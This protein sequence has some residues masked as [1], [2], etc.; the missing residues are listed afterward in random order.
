M[1][2]QQQIDGGFYSDTPYFFSPYST[3]KSL[4]EALEKAKP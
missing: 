1:T 2:Y 3:L 4:I